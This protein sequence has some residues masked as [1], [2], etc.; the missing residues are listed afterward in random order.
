MKKVFLLVIPA[1]LLIFCSWIIVK[2]RA[3]NINTWSVC[4][5]KKYLLRSFENEMGDTV[6]LENKKIKLTDILFV[7]RFLCGYSG[8][9]ATSILTIKNEQNEVVAESAVKGSYFNFSAQLPVQNILTSNKYTSNQVF[10]I[11]FSIDSKA[12][13]INETVLLGRMRIK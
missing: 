4:I 8:Q 3:L 9:E 5:G 7:H 11:F 12:E 1:I 6:V 13:E 10:G 2:E